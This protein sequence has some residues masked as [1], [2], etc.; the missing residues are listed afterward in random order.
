MKYILYGNGIDDDYPAIQEMLDEGRS[1]VLL[2]SPEKNYVISKTLKIHGGQC[3]KMSPFTLIKLAPGANCSMIEDCNFG[4]FKENICIDGGIWDMNHNEQLPNPYHF[5]DENGETWYDK[6][7]KIGYSSETATVPSALYTG[8]CMRF[9]RVKRLI[10]KNLTV[11]NP[12]TYGIQVYCTEDFDIRN[13]LFDYTE[14]SPKLWNMDGVHVEGYCKNGTIEN[15]KGACHDDLVAVTSDDGLYGPV[16]NIVI[17]NLFA[18]GCHSAVRLLSHGIPVKNVK[19]SNIYGSY[20]TYC[21]GITKYRGGDEERGNIKNIIIENVAASASQGTKDVAGGRFPFIWVE[22][23]INLDGLS[24][25]DVF[26][27]E[28]NYATPLLKIG[29]NAFVKELSLENIRQESEIGI[30]IP[31]LEIDGEADIVKQE[32]IKNCVK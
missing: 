25:K 31:L 9:C 17:N 28:K 18:E 16:E 12:V 29:K 21:I 24:I 32:N 14:G 27:E 1:E 3:L 7:K 8:M 19:I 6:A 13:I 5:A 4:S 11:K 20:Y 26:R 30:E 10:I 23:G 2:P 22:S 15:L